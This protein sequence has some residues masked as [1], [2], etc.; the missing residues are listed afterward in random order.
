M[1]GSARKRRASRAGGRMPAMMPGTGVGRSHSQ[2][3][4]EYVRQRLGTLL[5]APTKATGIAQKMMTAAVAAAEMSRRIARS[6]L[7]S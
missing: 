4:H 5:T 6:Y 1:T 7:S 2:A 3:S